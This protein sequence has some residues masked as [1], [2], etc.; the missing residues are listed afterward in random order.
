MAG[1]LGIRNVDERT[2]RLLQDYANERN[3]TMA[4]ALQEIMSLALEHLS[5][6][7]AKKYKSIFD[8]YD[9]IKFK[10][11]DPHLSEKIDEI[12]YGGN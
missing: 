10:S 11:N 12:L 7:K 6:K 5:E 9:K 1:M 8:T 4:E 2:K 3:M